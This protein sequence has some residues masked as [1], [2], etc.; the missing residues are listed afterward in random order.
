MWPPTVRC[1]YWGCMPLAVLFI[2]NHW[3]EAHHD[4]EIVDDDGRRLA[5]RWLPEG[6]EGAAAQ[7]ALVADHL[8]EDADA[9]QVVIGIETDRGP[10]VPALIAAGCTVYS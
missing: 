7:H 4:I 9:V 5:H 2:G 10:W 8:E 6:V 1:P 3:A